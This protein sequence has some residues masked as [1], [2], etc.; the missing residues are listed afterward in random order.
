[1]SRALTGLVLVAIIGLALSAIL[2]LGQVKPYVFAVAVLLTFSLVLV[3]VNGIIGRR[4][5][6]EAVLRQTQ[7]AVPWWVVLVT[8]LNTLLY[9]VKSN[10]DPYLFAMWWCALGAFVLTAIRLKQTKP[11]MFALTGD[12]LQI[13]GRDLTNRDLRNLTRIEFNGFFGFYRLRF[14]NARPITIEQHKFKEE[15]ADAFLEQVLRTAGPNVT[16]SDNLVGLGKP[17]GP[18][19]P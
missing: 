19:T 4:V 10:K 8:A 12:E 2:D 15:E 1:M 17:E 18:M 5:S 3:H 13:N 7:A 6:G 14:S 11:I 16:L 9:F